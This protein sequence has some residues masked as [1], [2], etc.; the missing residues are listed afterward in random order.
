MGYALAYRS[1]NRH[2]RSTFVDCKTE[3]R[4]LKVSAL[5]ATSCGCRKSRGALDFVDSSRLIVRTVG[6]R[7]RP[8]EFGSL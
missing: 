8:D 1:S 7:V 2:S 6:V 5:T 4:S 3:R